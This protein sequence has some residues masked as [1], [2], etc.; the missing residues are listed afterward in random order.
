MQLQHMPAALRTEIATRPF[1][2][3]DRQRRLN[4]TRQSF[5]LRQGG[6]DRRGSVRKSQEDLTGLGT[7]SACAAPLP[8]CR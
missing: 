7:A 2:R 5:I 6:T 4:C 1:M 3:V 8:F